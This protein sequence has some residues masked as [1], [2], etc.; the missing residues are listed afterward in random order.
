M[1]AQDTYSSGAKIPYS[2]SV[3][4]AARGKKSPVGRK[5]Q[6]PDAILV[7]REC[8]ALSRREV[9]DSNDSLHRSTCKESPVARPCVRVESLWRV[10]N[11][12]LF[13]SLIPY[14]EVVLRR[15]DHRSEPLI[16]GF[17]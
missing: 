13:L 4:T 16:A 10:Q 5:A 2:H 11:A 12:K 14:G 15:H 1:S 9:P 7:A 3:V 8:S 17:R 6:T